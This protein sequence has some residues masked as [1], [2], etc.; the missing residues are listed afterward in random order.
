[1][2]YNRKRAAKKSSRKSATEEAICLDFGKNVCGPNITTNDVYYKSQLNVYA[3]NIHILSTAQ[4][5]FYVYPETVAKKGS[6][7]VRE[8][9]LYA[10]CSM[11]HDF[12]YNFLDTKVRKLVIFCDSCGGQNKNFTMFRFLHNVVH[13]QHRLDY[14]KVI[15]PI[16]GHSYME[17]DKN[18][19]LV[20]TKQSAEIPSDWIGIFRDART[21]PSPFDVVEVQQAHFRAWTEFF[22]TNSD[23]VKKCPMAF[24]PVRELDIRRVHP[25]LLYYRTT[26]NEMWESAVMVNK[27]VRSGPILLENEFVLPHNSYSGKNYFFASSNL[28]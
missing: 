17:P 13:N 18:M 7:A 28:L 26:Y 21:K 9:M 24:R 4:S 25:R 8:V 11:L 5:V 20:N 3:F 1:M 16:R 6:D 19:G 27:T 12:L 2:F 23:Y 14:V 15:F 10:L 22:K